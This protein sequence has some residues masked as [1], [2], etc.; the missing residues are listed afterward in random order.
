MHPFACTSRNPGSRLHPLPIAHAL[1]FTCATTCS[2]T[3]IARSEKNIH[4]NIENPPL[5]HHTTTFIHFNLHHSQPRW[6]DLS[7]PQKLVKVFRHRKPLTRPPRQAQVFRLDQLWPIPKRPEQR[8]RASTRQSRISVTASKE[9]LAPPTLHPSLIRPLSQRCQSQ[10]RC[11]PRGG[12]LSR[13]RG[14]SLDVNLGQT[15]R[16]YL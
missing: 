5:Q 7:T 11:K 13:D 8:H 4:K 16:S 2:Y 14:T 12:L 6:L 9:N 3:F 10:T 1:H 15:G